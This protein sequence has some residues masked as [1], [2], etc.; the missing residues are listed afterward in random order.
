[1]ASRVEPIPFEDKPILLIRASPGGLGAVRGL[2]HTRV[3]LEAIGAHMYPEMMGVSRAHQAFD[4][5]GRLQDPNQ[6]FRLQGL[7]L[8]YSD[9]VR[10]LHGYS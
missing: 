5:N 10:K 9:F 8:S 6:L 3:P 4:G 7:L 1:L 2:W